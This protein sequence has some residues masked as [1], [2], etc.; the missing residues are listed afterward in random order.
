MTASRQPQRKPTPRER[1]LVHIDN[2]HRQ[3]MRG[4]SIATVRRRTSRLLR[5]HERE[6]AERGMSAVPVRGRRGS[7]AYMD[8]LA[9]GR[10]VCTAILGPPRK[11]GAR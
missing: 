9:L 4:D 3:F 6:L 10:A 8:S 11:K 2:T 1:L 5:E 7:A